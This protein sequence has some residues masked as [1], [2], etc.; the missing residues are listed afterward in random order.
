[1]RKIKIISQDFGNDI[2]ET[3]CNYIS[4]MHSVSSFT[5][6][7]YVSFSVLIRYFLKT[8]IIFK[9]HLLLVEVTDLKSFSCL[10]FTFYKMIQ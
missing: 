5:A 3:P 6:F 2:F 9:T 7:I 4:I 10:S 8:C 1:M